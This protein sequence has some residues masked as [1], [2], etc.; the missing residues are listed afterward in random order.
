MAS[1][2]PL[3]QRLSGWVGANKQSIRNSDPVLDLGDVARGLTPRL[4]SCL[5]SPLVV[6]QSL[7]GVLSLYSHSPKAFTEDH[8]RVI[9]VFAR[10][11]APA[12]Q[13]MSEKRSYAGLKEPEPAEVDL[14]DTV[15]YPTGSS[16]WVYCD[17]RNYFWKTC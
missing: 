7:V 17:C 6:G 15:T 4:R 14:R 13:A 2:I 16:A 10:Q 3:G 12:L 8:Q 5:S 1:R 9:E 11:V